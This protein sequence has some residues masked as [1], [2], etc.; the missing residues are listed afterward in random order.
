MRVIS[1]I[2]HEHGGHTFIACRTKLPVIIPGLSLLS[3]VTDIAKQKLSCT[4]KYCKLKVKLHNYTI[5]F[6]LSDLNAFYENN[7]LL[8]DKFPLNRILNFVHLPF[9]HKILGGQS[10]FF[11]YFRTRKTCTYH[12]HISVHESIINI[13]NARFK[14]YWGIKRYYNTVQN[15]KL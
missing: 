4:L 10:V 12:Q 6:W 15:R 8:S 3:P 2:N 9:M 5:K 13:I 7:F 11:Y 1:C 14:Y